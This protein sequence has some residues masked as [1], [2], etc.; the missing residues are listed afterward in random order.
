MDNIHVVIR[1]RPLNE[2]ELSGGQHPAWLVQEGAFIHQVT[3]DKK[4]VPGT[5]GYAF[6][7]SNI[8]S[9]TSTDKVYE[10]QHTSELYEQV[11]L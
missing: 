9:L 7:M 5:A 4:P 1:V 6:G 2:R 3:A 11:L 10:D 8:P